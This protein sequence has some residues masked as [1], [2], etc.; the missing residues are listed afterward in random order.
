MSTNG[1]NARLDRIEKLIE[2]SEL[3]SKK[4]HERIEKDLVPVE[5]D[6]RRWAAL[7]VQE[8]RRQRKRAAEIDENIDRLASAQL[9]TGEKL[10][11]FIS[12]LGRDRNGGKH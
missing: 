9:V 10:Q 2:Q 5:R 6:L 3:A 8:G 1:S 11:L 4:A 12:T 7:G